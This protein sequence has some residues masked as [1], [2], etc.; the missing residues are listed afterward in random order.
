MKIE[1]D[2]ILFLF[3]D[4]LLLQPEVSSD[5]DSHKKIPG[6]LFACDLIFLLLFLI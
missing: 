2:S 1:M 6:S 5:C 4:P 3:S